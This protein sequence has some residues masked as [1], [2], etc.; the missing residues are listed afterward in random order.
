MAATSSP[1]RYQQRFVIN[2]MSCMSCVGKIERALLSLPNVEQVHIQLS[3]KTAVVYSSQPVALDELLHCVHALGFK[4]YA[5]ETL[6]INIQGLRCAGCVRK[7]ENALLA[8]PAVNH[9]FIH[10]TTHQA[11]ITLDSHQHRQSVLDQI[12]TLGYQATIVEKRQTSQHQQLQQQ[13][14]QEIQQLKYRT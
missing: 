4:A 10:P 9:V 6:L 5:P 8:L 13:Q 11:R 2:G 1:T 14:T 12:A 7:V 3:Q